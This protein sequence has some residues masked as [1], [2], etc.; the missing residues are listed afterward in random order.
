MKENDLKK[1][2]SGKKQAT[3]RKHDWNQAKI[4]STHQL[5]LNFNE[6]PFGWAE[7]GNIDVISLLDL[8]IRDFEVLGYTSANEYLSEDFNMNQDNPFRKWISMPYIILNPDFDWNGHKIDFNKAIEDSKTWMHFIVKYAD[9]IGNPCNDDIFQTKKDN[10]TATRVI[11]KCIDWYF[12][13]RMTKAYLNEDSDKIIQILDEIISVY[14]YLDINPDADWLN[15]DVLPFSLGNDKI[16][17]DTLCISINTGTLCCMGLTGRCENHKICYAVASNKMYTAEFLKNNISQRHFMTVH[18]DVLGLKT[19]ELIKSKLTKSQLANLKFI[20][21]SING[22]ILNNEWLIRLNRI[23]SIL[24]RGLGI[25]IAYTY[26]HNKE[27]DL[28]LASD[29]LINCSFKND[30]QKCCLTAM[31]FDKSMMEDESIIVCN[32]DCNR[33]SYCKNPDEDRTV[34]FLAHGG[35]Y[36]GVKQIPDVIMQELIRQKENDYLKFIEEYGI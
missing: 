12:K 32:G 26:T 35:K 11:N 23:A 13:N 31:Q 9:K 10:L 17:E 15:P 5:R 34:I 3:C 14:R 2:A 16:G 30:S 29:I 20:R 24:K 27:L 7:I 1:F 33:C 8:K 4:G 19:L 28:D 21:F 18:P 36:K 6:N 22:D 25:K